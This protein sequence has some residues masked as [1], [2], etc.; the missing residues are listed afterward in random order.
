MLE[1]PAKPC[2]YTLA[3]SLVDSEPSNNSDGSRQAS[4]MYTFTIV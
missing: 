1:K 3:K 2:V 4:P